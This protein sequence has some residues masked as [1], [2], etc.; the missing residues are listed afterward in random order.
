MASLRKPLPKFT[1]LPL[2]KEDPPNSAWGLWGDSKEASLGSLNYLT[3]DLVLRTI[4]EEVMTGERLG[5]ECVFFS[6][7]CFFRMIG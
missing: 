1:D 3:D 7:V 4:K 2:H 5:L 6:N